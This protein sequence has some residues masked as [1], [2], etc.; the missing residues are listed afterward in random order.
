MNTLTFVNSMR[1]YSFMHEYFWK[2]RKAPVV[3]TVLWNKKIVGIIGFPSTLL[4]FASFFR[5]F[6]SQQTMVMRSRNL[7]TWRNN[8]LHIEI[9]YVILDMHKYH[10]KETNYFYRN[11]KLKELNQKNC[12][13]QI[14]H[15]LHHKF[16]VMTEIKVCFQLLILR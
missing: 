1:Y 14:I 3:S 4:E 8:G 2:Y 7:K 13:I 15:C 11:S 9:C 6:T 12:R 5:G 16:R 10:Q